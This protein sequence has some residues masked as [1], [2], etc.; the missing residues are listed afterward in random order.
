MDEPT[1]RS[2]ADASPSSQEQQEKNGAALSPQGPVTSAV[3]DVGRSKPMRRIMTHLAVLGLIGLG[4]WAGRMG[5]D[6]L[7]L[8]SGRGLSAAVATPT[9][10]SEPS[11]ALRMSILPSLETARSST[12]D[13]IGR[14]ADPLTIIPSRSRVSVFKY[15]VQK[16]DSI[17]GIAEK[18]ALKPETVLWG[19]FDVL[20]D[21]P[22]FLQPDQELNILPVDGTLHIWV[23]GE[24]LEAVAQFYRVPVEEVIDFPG[25]NLPPDIDRESSPISPGSALVIPGGKRE[26]ISW[27]APRIPRANPAVARI[28]GPGACG[29]IYDGPVG[30]GG[31]IWP[32]VLRY[33]SGYDYSPGSNHWGIDIAGRE[34]NAIYASDSGVV[35]YSGW[36]NGGYGNVIVID[37]G[38]AWQ[39]LYAH[40]SQVNVG[41]GDGVF[42]GAVIGLLGSTG[43]STGPHLHF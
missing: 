15:R 31:F 38:N 26:F 36:H 4:V 32:T 25:N 27:S 14:R 21:N 28:L 17:F 40:L 22:H 7:S 23:E 29:S 37:H 39:T 9:Q 42:Q 12:A 6:D 8:E 35:V 11:N 1:N 5:L 33:L 41:C 30:S 18:F 13:G 16:G 3:G 24:G 34:G 43:R 10:A 20:Q 19:N 2:L